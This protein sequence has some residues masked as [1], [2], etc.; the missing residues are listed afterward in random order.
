MNIPKRLGHIWIGSRK[1]P[2]RWMRTWREKHPHW[3]YD[4]YGNEYLRQ[5]EF[6]NQHLI[7]AYMKTGNYCGVADLMRY[8][9]L[10]RQ[11]GLLA[12]S[13]NE[14]HH[15]TDELWKEGR[16]FTSYENEFLRGKLVSPPLACQPGNEFIE[17]LVEELHKLTPSD[18]GPPWMSVANLFVARMIAVHRPD[19]VIFP[20]HYFN[21]MHYEGAVYSGPTRFTLG[22]IS[23]QQNICMERCRNGIGS[24]SGISEG[25]CAIKCELSH[26]SRL[27]IQTLQQ[28]VDKL[29]RPRFRVAGQ[30]PLGQRQAMKLNTLQLGAM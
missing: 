19:I 5:T 20:S 25:S 4:L 8:E 12:N 22:S 10:L 27:Q 7:D 6:R 15:C 29:K 3:Q 14:C 2:E 30:I 1:P 23:A 17:L 26:R 16:V 28:A 11:G 21:P 9:I 13:D 24:S 18:L